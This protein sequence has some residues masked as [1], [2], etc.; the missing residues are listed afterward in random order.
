MRKIRHRIRKFLLDRTEGA[1]AV[2]YIIL[3][4]VVALGIVIGLQL[5]QGSVSDYYAGVGTNLEGYS[6]ADQDQGQG[7]GRG[8]GH[9]PP[10]ASPLD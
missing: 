7:P 1:G 8:R 10:T 9:G 6:A 2:D 5:Y 4:A 3:V